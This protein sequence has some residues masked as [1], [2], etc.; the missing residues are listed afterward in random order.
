[1][2]RMRSLLTWFDQVAH[3]M[4]KFGI[5]GGLGYLADFTIFNLLR[6]AGG[7]G[8]LHDKPLTAKLIS[9]AV[10]TTITYFGNRHWTWRQR[11][12]EA[13]RAAVHREYVL[14]LVFNAVGAGISLLCLFMSH[15]VLDLRGP[16]ADNVSANGVGLLLGTTFRYWSYGKFVF[17]ERE[18]QRVQ[19]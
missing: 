1:M 18:P 15:Y 12:R 4:L 7:S 19:L 10:A 8:P 13:G 9:A 16:V 11:E 6:Y 17:R 3:R 5:I 14:F 2:T